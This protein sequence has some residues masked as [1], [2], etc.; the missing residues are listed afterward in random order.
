MDSGI[1]R[2]AMNLERWQWQVLP[3]LCLRGWRSPPSGK[4]LLHFIH[5]NGYCGLVYS[6]LL[7]LLGVD[8]D[9]F[10]SDV[11]GHGDSDKGG[12]FHG[13]N[14]TA[15]LCEQAFRQHLP[16]YQTAQGLPSVFAVGHSFGGVMSML[17]SA[18]QPALFDRLA[19]L[20][21]V[22][23]SPMMIGVMAMSD[24]LGLWQR[25]TLASRTRK[26]RTHWPDAQ[27]AYQYCHGRGMFKGW[28]EEALWAY[29][30][31][32]LK[33]DPAGLTLKC[34]PGFEAAVF[35]SYPKRLWSSVAALKKPTL[36]LCGSDSY[37]FVAESARKAAA[38]NPVIKQR[39]LPGGHCFMQQFP[40]ETAGCIREFLLA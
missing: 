22:V 37:P 9:L 3:D 24:L 8:F 18:K 36:M 35:G 29:V 33:P 38:M 40:A 7:R 20:D 28:T 31:Q 1:T 19:L 10:I 39:M 5:G 14:R 26:R 27:A 21:P 15:A 4:P 16:D 6:P 12:R 13:W 30:E 17:I 11:Q 25:N 32:A 23:F 34:R 2:S